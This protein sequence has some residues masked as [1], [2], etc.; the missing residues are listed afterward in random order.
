MVGGRRERRFGAASGETTA[1]G[2]VNPN[3]GQSLG[4]KQSSVN[5]SVTVTLISSAN[6]EQTPACEQILHDKIRI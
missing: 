6:T 2:V 3:V 4:S 5:A 1:I